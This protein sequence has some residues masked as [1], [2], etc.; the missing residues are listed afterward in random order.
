MFILCE[1]LYETFFSKHSAKNEQKYKRGFFY[2][3]THTHTHPNMD[4]V[5]HLFTFFCKLL[6]LLLFMVFARG[7]GVCRFTLRNPLKKQHICFKNIKMVA[8]RI[9]EIEV[10]LEFSCGCL[11]YL[12]VLAC[13][14]AAVAEERREENEK[15]HI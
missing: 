11:F 5:E 9:V 14:V 1:I 8:V 2:T 15:R 7:A 10:T 3:Q 6:F 4:Q 12:I 13:T